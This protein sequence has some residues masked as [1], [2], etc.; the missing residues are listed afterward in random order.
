MYF[1]FLQ[2]TCD[3]DASLISKKPLLSYGAVRQF[4]LHTVKQGCIC[5]S[6]PYGHSILY[7]ATDSRVVQKKIQRIFI[8]LTI[9]ILPDFINPIKSPRSMNALEQCLRAQHPG[10]ARL[11]RF[12]L[13]KERAQQLLSSA[14]TVSFCA[15]FL[16][17]FVGEPGTARYQPFEDGICKD[18]IQRYVQTP[19]S[20]CQCLRSV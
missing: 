2:L 16:T 1:L 19:P 7:T 18:A 3:L 4:S 9:L 11:P 13:L 10:Q 8:N 20:W 5:H 6:I 15:S 12:D 17:M 14:R